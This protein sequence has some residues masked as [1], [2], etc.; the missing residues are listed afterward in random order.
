MHFT[1]LRYVGFGI[2]HDGEEFRGE[3]VLTPIS[4]T[5]ALAYTYKAFLT[6]GEKIHE[7]SGI[8]SFDETGNSVVANHMDELPCVTLHRLFKQQERC[9]HFS[10]TGVGDIA[11]FNSELVFEFLD[12][13]FKYKHRWAMG[14]DPEDKSWCELKPQA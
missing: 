10:Y 14:G 2:N 7:E 6:D 4:N 8:F 11:G 9:F 13:G 1:A 5:P 12:S 3:F